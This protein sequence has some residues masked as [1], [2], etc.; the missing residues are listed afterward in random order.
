M[1]ACVSG[2]LGY[3]VWSE[4]VS[5]WVMK[6]DV[7]ECLSGGLAQGA[8]SDAGDDFQGDRGVDERGGEAPGGGGRDDRVVFPGEDEGGADDGRQVAG[9]VC[10]S[11]PAGAEVGEH[12]I[13]QARPGPA[14]PHAGLRRGVAVEG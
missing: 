9:R 4:G 3:M 14:L 1:D 2:V 5:V 7:G 6:A 13:V 12:L 10:R 11:A 8:V